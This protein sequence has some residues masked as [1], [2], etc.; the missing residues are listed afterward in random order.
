MRNSGLEVI[1]HIL[2]WVG[3]G[4]LIVS[5]FSIQSHEIE[6]IN[7]VETARIV[8]GNGLIYQLLLC[9]AIAMVAFY[10]NVRLIIKSNQK[11]TS[12]IRNSF[13]VLLIV[14]ILIYISTG[15]QIFKDSPPLPNEIAFGIAVFYFSLSVAYG[16]VKNSIDN[17]QR[18][19]QLML[20]KKQ[21]ELALLRNQL[22]PHFLF[23]ALN[24]LLSMAY[25]S[26]NPKLADSLDKLSQLL[27]FLVEY[28]MTEKIPITKEIEF[29]KNYIDLQMLRFEEGEVNVRF[30]VKGEYKKQKVEPGLFIP[31]V[32]N[33]FKYGT[34][35]EKRTTIDIEFDV[36][37]QH[38]IIFKI[39][40]SKMITNTNGSGTGIGTTKK[41][42]ELIY[43]KKHHLN[44]VE[45][46]SEFIVDLSIATE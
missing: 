40:N 19:Q 21:A 26:D 45:T 6:V 22:Q 35:P 1:V 20:D 12:K 2:F 15:I 17:H 28:N 3:T 16:L 7:G 31:F 25:P 9:I 44:I 34:E 38:S 37:N 39:M 10:V 5:G 41:R 24:N 11:E 18:H 43:H 36:T 14:M 33:S 8:R 30:K 13:L 32:E 29:L 46:D 4:W 27:R 42:L 23:N